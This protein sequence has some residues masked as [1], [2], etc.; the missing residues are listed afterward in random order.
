MTIYRRVHAKKVMGFELGG[1]FFVPTTEIERP[2][3]EGNKQP[4]E[5]VPRK[6]T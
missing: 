2:K 3:R 4:Q 6:A 1:M 5:A